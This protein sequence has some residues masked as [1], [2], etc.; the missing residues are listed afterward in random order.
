M[1]KYTPECPFCG[2]HITAPEK[3]KAELGEIIA[4]RCACGAVYVCDPTGH[5]MGEAYM[6]ALAF[7]KGDWDIY[8]MSPD[9]DYFMTDMDYDLKRHARL[10]SKSTGEGGGKLIFVKLTGSIMPMEVKQDIANETKGACLS[11]SQLKD[12]LAN[13]RY[14]EIVRA[15]NKD[16]GI[17][18]R[19]I[20][21]TYD[22][23]DVISWRAME[24]LGIIAGE[25][26]RSG[27]TEVIR[28]IIRR[29]L[30]SMGEESGGIG[31]S[32]PEMLGEIIRSNPDEFGD[33]IP[34]LWSFR[35]EEMF[36]G[37]IVWAMARIGSVRPDLVNFAIDEMEIMVA[38]KN[39]YVRGYVAWFFCIIGGE[40]F[41]GHLKNLSDGEE[42]INFYKDGELIK[43]KVRDI[44]GI[45]TNKN[46]K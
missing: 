28:D 36:R 27:K 9:T 42:I 32:S 11:K 15:A 16:K 14:D 2:K 4:G 43:R 17:L 21:S 29:L 34:I 26:S 35:E 12:L 33:I 3:I 6:E 30:W 45:L 39:P 40:D 5:N 1:N 8:S 46:I 38:D 41:I 31:W 44:A 19:L 22:K 18:R 23:D 37:G 7:A 24:A 10:Y 25:F 20:S 13:S